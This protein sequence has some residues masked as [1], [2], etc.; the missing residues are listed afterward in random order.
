MEK[1]LPRH[2]ASILTYCRVP[3]PPSRTT[4]T[5]LLAPL[6]PG[7]AGLPPSSTNA[8]CSPSR[9][10]PA[11]TPRSRAAVPSPHELGPSSSGWGGG[12]GWRGK[13]KFLRLSSGLHTGSEGLLQRLSGGEVWEGLGY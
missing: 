3:K 8:T 12:V 6:K 2:P 11:A 4:S 1:P 9:R 5:A 13:G 7:S 10:L